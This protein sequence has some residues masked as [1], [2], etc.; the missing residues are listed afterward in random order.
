M[1]SPNAGAPKIRLAT[2]VKDSCTRRSGSTNPVLARPGDPITDDGLDRRLRAADLCLRRWDR[3]ILA[4]YTLRKVQAKKSRRSRYVEGSGGVM[5][6]SK[7]ADV[8][9]LRMHYLEWG[10][11]ANP[12]LLL[13]HGWTGL[14]V[15]WTSVAEAFQDRYHIIAP[16]NRGH[17]QTDKPVT[18]LHAAR[19]CDRRRELDRCP[20]TG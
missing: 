13:I 7:F 6:E 20:R 9:G 18:R 4:C 17:G 16:D 10:D 19:F 1:R 3:R 2:L 5:P 8:Q 15:A 12:D 14:G 11:S